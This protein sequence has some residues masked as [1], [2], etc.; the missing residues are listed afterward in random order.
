MAW[1]RCKVNQA[2]PISDGTETPNPVI[3]INLTELEGRFAPNQWFFAADNCK[4]QMLAA[5]LSAI[6]VGA[7]VTVGGA[8]P[9]VNNDPFTQIDRLYVNAP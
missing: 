9:N 7:T 6:T 2:G 8:P 1:Y 5:A 3:Y 4:S